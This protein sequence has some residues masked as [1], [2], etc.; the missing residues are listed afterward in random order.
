M[1]GM[2]SSS[3]AAMRTAVIPTTNSG[4]SQQV[5]IKSEMQQSQQQHRKGS[6]QHDMNGVWANGDPHAPALQQHQS[7]V[8]SELPSQNRGGN[9][10]DMEYDHD[11]AHGSAGNSNGH[12]QNNDRNFSDHQSVGS[13]S[14]ASSSPD[15]QLQQ[16]SSSSSGR[17]SDRSSQHTSPLVS[18]PQSP[19]QQP[20]TPN[21]LHSNSPV[22]RDLL[23]QNNSPAPRVTA[24]NSSSGASTASQP[25]P[26]GLVSTPVSSTDMLLAVNLHLGNGK[27]KTWPTR[28]I[29]LQSL[30]NPSLSYAQLLFHAANISTFVSVSVEGR[31]IPDALNSGTT[32]QDNPI[33]KRRM[34]Q[35]I[36]HSR[37]NSRENSRSS[38]GH[39]RDSHRSTPTHLNSQGGLDFA[40]L[41]I[42]YQLSENV[43]SCTRLGCVNLL[44]NKANRR[45]CNICQSQGAEI[46]P[47][48]LRRLIINP[49]SHS[50][51][52]YA[53]LEQILEDYEYWKFDSLDDHSISASASS[54]AAAAAASAAP[55]TAN[56]NFPFG[57]QIGYYIAFVDAA[58]A[59]HVQKDFNQ[60]I[61]FG[62]TT[63]PDMHQV[64][65]Q[66]DFVIPHGALGAGAGAVDPL[67]TRIVEVDPA[68]SYSCR[69]KSHFWML[70]VKPKVT[71]QNG[72]GAS[73]KPKSKFYKKVGKPNQS[74]AASAAAAIVAQQHAA[75]HAAAGTNGFPLGFATKTEDSSFHPTPVG[76]KRRF[77]AAGGSDDAIIPAVVGINPATGKFLVEPGENHN[78]G[79][80]NN[81]VLEEPTTNSVHVS[82][83]SFRVMKN[84]PVSAM[85][86]VHAAD[87]TANAANGSAGPVDAKPLVSAPTPV[88]LVYRDMDAY[89]KDLMLNGGSAAGFGA[90]GGRG[91]FDGGNNPHN[92]GHGGGGGGAD[93]NPI[94]SNKRG[95]F[96]G[97]GGSQL[98]GG[99]AAGLSI[100][101]MTPTPALLA[102]AVP[103]LNP[104]IAAAAMNQQIQ[105]AQAA[106]IQRQIWASQQN[107]LGMQQMDFGRFPAPYLFSDMASAAA[108]DDKVGGD[109]IELTDIRRKELA[110][111]ATAGRSSSFLGDTADQL[112]TE[113]EKSGTLDFDGESM[114]RG[115][116][117]GDEVP[118]LPVASSEGGAPITSPNPH[119]VRVRI[120]GTESPL[121]APFSPVSEEGRRQTLRAQFAA[122]DPDLG[123][124]DALLM[125]EEHDAMQLEAPEK[126]GKARSA[127]VRAE[128]L[129]NYNVQKQRLIAATT[130]RKKEVDSF[131]PSFTARGAAPFAPFF[132]SFF[133]FQQSFWGV[134]FALMFGLMG[135]ILIAQNLRRANSED[136]AAVKLQLVTDYHLDTIDNTNNN[137]NYIDGR[138][139]EDQR[140]GDRHR[141]SFLS[142]LF[143]DNDDDHRH[144]HHHDRTH[145]KLIEKPAFDLLAGAADAEV[146]AAIIAH[147]M[148]R[149]SSSNSTN[150]GS[151][152]G[153]DALSRKLF[154]SI[155]M[156]A[157]M[158]EAS[159]IF[160]VWANTNPTVVAALVNGVPGAPATV[161]TDVIL[162]SCLG[163]AKIAKS[164]A[165]YILSSNGLLAAFASFST[166]KSIPAVLNS[167]QLCSNIMAD[168]NNVGSSFLYYLTCTQWIQGNSFSAFNPPPSGLS[169][170]SWDQWQR[171]LTQSNCQDLFTLIDHEVM[172]N[173]FFNR[174]GK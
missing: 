55:A 139:G 44:V 133:A 119:A 140:G 96:D 19:N 128:Q 69:M 17:S 120:G 154:T 162:S 165:D 118:E 18:S 83:T 66:Q 127:G 75:V 33:V 25:S 135:I 98:S 88:V 101:P 86:N 93:R 150:S 61:G 5:H 24:S 134:L 137:L 100:T 156:L 141:K 104:M 8:G 107:Q 108:P 159:V 122:M 111:N 62:G 40:P 58:T 148:S 84:Q 46:S 49:H 92:G 171:S 39:S 60:K 76:H 37:A 149:D 78:N 102:N 56:A 82:D 173:A 85:L 115:V 10:T 157:S 143:G 65:Q 22:P 70:E 163:A 136:Q 12:S 51:T 2:D 99:V 43:K 31:E 112:G 14:S 158:R 138:F 168:D 47:S 132:K 153:G 174:K 155:Q 59:A 16:A 7:R 97:P 164:V 117:P 152:T 13:V 89:N 129:D 170:Q 30:A 9:H 126:Q 91:A 32:V 144:S 124:V 20:I 103:G 77:E 53:Y 123:D 21:P 166:P 48:L 146:P 26:N 64:Q 172:T 41:E 151:G 74:R 130:A 34:E 50:A 3:A 73:T 169:C 45:A 80:N 109:G 57:N 160:N 1:S 72:S 167:N 87:T 95:R 114:S 125:L 81:E 36:Q 15:V 106:Q 110:S 28:V 79:S 63:N 23:R 71:N 29:S 105:L 121:I 142:R 68:F 42:T 161:N 90:N 54:A 67:P 145:E 52:Q 38:S 113:E 116:A 27:K 94:G 131:Y 4:Y 147:H 6:F 35:L 11:G